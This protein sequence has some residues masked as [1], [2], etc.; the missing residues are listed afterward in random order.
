MNLKLEVF[1]NTYKHDSFKDLCKV[2]LRF[3]Y[4]FLTQKIL[5]DSQAIFSRFLSDF[6]AILELFENDYRFISNYILWEH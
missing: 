1:F 6:F 3:F 4:Y 5:C 2:L